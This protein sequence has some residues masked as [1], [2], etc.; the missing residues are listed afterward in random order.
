M[1]PLTDTRR[2]ILSAANKHADGFALPPPHLPPAPRIAV[3]KALLGAGLLA[4]ADGAEG[5]RPGLR[6]KLDGERVLLRI[7]EAGLGAIGAV[8]AEAPPEP[9]QGSGA[10]PAG[11]A[12]AVAQDGAVAAAARRD[13]AQQATVAS[14]AAQG[15]SVAIP[16]QTRREALRSAAQAVLAAW[17][18][19][20]GEHA[21]L[22]EAIEQLRQALAKSAAVRSTPGPRSPRTGTKQEAVLALLRRPEGASGPQII[23]ATGWA[24]HTVRGFLAGLKKRG[25]A[26]LVHD[27]VRQVGPGKA[28]TKG[29]YSIYR[30]AEV[31]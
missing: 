18:D 24:P 15:A 1:K 14:E 6:W 26:V 28:G 19:A 17:D 22:A 23:A 5:Q 30:I 25:V 3:A 16:R 13:A 12:A 11:Q 4:R 9:R 31:G 20:Q 10:E 2:A 21:G 8:P 7:T 29:S 27:R